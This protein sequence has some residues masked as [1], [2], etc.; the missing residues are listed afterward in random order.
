M[1]DQP[2]IHIMPVGGGF[3]VLIA[4][5]GQDAAWSADGARIAYTGYNSDSN[6]YTLWTM[7]PDGTDKVRLTAP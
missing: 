2:G 5:F 4:P 7:R 3:N 6:T 1:A